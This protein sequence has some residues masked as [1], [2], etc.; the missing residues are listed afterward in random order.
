MGLVASEAGQFSILLVW[1]LAKCKIRWFRILHRVD[2]GNSIGAIAEEFHP[3]LNPQKKME[4]LIFK[5]KNSNWACTVSEMCRGKRSSALQCSTITPNEV[6]TVDKL[7]G[8]A[9]SSFFY[10]VCKSF[11]FVLF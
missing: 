6:H 9:F 5:K 3:P 4:F 11:S 1:S 7:N 10:N 2:N 8:T